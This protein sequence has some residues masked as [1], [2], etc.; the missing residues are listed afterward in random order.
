MLLGIALFSS[1]SR[2]SR[3]RYYICFDFVGVAFVMYRKG[4]S[5]SGCSG[6]ELKV[7]RDF[8]C[9]LVLG[10]DAGFG[11]AYPLCVVAVVLVGGYAQVVCM[12]QVA[13]HLCLWKVVRRWW[14]GRGLLE[15][16]RHCSM[17]VCSE[18]VVARLRYNGVRDG[19]IWVIVFLLFHVF[20]LYCLLS[21]VLGARFPH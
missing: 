9:S 21:G 8:E 14:R 15:E 3:V 6:F 10:F 19:M 5:T 16:C 13:W 11:L 12:I 18:W 17:I 4:C 7:E 1:L 20:P 2:S